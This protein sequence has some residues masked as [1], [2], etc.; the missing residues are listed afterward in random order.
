M[1]RVKKE[2]KEKRNAPI[3]LTMGAP[4]PAKRP[5]KFGSSNN[6]IMRGAALANESRSKKSVAKKAHTFALLADAAYK[7]K[8]ERKAFLVENGLKGFTYS[9]MSTD[10]VAI[11]NKG[12]KHFV[13]FRGTEL[14]RGAETALKDLGSDVLVGLGAINASSRYAD[15]QEVIEALLQAD[16]KGVKDIVLV[17][18]SLGGTIA[19]ALGKEYEMEVHA[20]N[21]GAF[22]GPVVEGLDTLK[23]MVTGEH[24]KNINTYLS[25][26]DPIS[27]LAHIEKG[28][29]HLFWSEGSNVHSID[30]FYLDKEEEEDLSV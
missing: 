25:L 14:N 23:D 15:G 18:H 5:K 19:T 21:P 22:L 20:F 13:V 8:K 12:K 10:E 28:N 17:G 7:P 2:R 1:A 16:E 6:R 29:K 9:R 11:F 4:P 30:N 26:G 27:S 24:H 3:D